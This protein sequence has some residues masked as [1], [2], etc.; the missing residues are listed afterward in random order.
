MFCFLFFI[1]SEV[2][3]FPSFPHAMATVVRVTS[4]CCRFSGE[5][6]QIIPLQVDSSAGSQAEAGDVLHS[7]G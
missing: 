4:L 1:F 6:I 7:S 3:L 5:I 2:L